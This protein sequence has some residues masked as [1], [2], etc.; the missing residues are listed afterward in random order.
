MKEAEA[1]VNDTL[2]LNP[3]GLIAWAC[4]ASHE[5]VDHVLTRDIGEDGRSPWI[6]LRLANGDLALAVFPR[7]NTYEYVSHDAEC[8]FPAV[9]P[10]DKIGE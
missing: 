6:W 8:D 3:P 1:I 9:P 5:A 10:V 7:G 2:D 4:D